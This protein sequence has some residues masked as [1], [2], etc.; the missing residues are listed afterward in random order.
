MFFLP[1]VSE[2]QTQQTSHLHHWS[3]E[4]WNHSNS[5]A[6]SESVVRLRAWAALCS[7]TDCTLQNTK[8]CSCILMYVAGPPLG[9]CSAQPTQPYVM[10]LKLVQTIL[11]T[12]LLLICA[13]F[14]I[15]SYENEE[16]Q[17]GSGL[18]IYIFFL[19]EGNVAKKKTHHSFSRL[20]FIMPIS[21]SSPQPP[22][23]STRR[24][25]AGYL[26]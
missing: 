13:S 15:V 1:L 17:E 2:K 19:N 20:P 22:L 18:Y 8:G 16:F 14:S 7:C 12:H 21:V 5:K 4:L 25:T 11:F 9:S 26:V 6:P 10:T 24:Q 3:Q 23:P